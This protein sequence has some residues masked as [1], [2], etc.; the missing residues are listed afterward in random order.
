MGEVLNKVWYTIEGKKVTNVAEVLKEIVEKGEAEIHIGT[1]SQNNALFTEYVTVIAIITKGKGGRALYIT[2]K[3]P[4]IKLLRE[5]LLK[6]VW[7]SVAVALEATEIIGDA[8]KLQV[9]V[10]VNPDTDF[11]SSGYIKELTAMVVSQ[12]FECKVKPD[13]WAAMHVADHVVKHKV[14]ARDR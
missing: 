4:R 14:I 11:K 6:E 8:S 10:D 7:S 13:A 5:R 3:V 2:E 1:D 12:G 9:H